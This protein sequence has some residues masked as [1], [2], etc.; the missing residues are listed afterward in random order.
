MWKSLLWLWLNPTVLFVDGSLSLW[1]YV[2]GLDLDDTHGQVECVA[3]MWM[4]LALLSR[5]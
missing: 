3:L 1:Q 2:D 4:L 5:L